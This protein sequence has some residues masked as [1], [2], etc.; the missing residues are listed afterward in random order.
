MS[1][2]LVNDCVVIPH[3][4][5][6]ANKVTHTR[7][8]STKVAEG[9]TGAEDRAQLKTQPIRALDCE[10]LAMDL[11]PRVELEER[12]LVAMQKGRAA[13]PLWS[14]PSEL[15]AQAGKTSVSLVNRVWPWRPGDY[16]IFMSPRGRGRNRTLQINCGGAA[17][18]PFLSDMDYT[19]GQPLS[20]ASAIRLGYAPDPAPAA[21]Y[22]TARVA[23][24]GTQEN[25]IAYAITGLDPAVGCMVRVHVAEIDP[26]MVPGS[27]NASPY[28]CPSA[29]QMSVTV[30]GDTVQTAANVVPFAA[31]HF[32]IYTPTVLEFW[33]YPDLTGTITITAAGIIESIY[34]GPTYYFP[35]LISALEVFQCSWEVRQLI[36][37]T[38]RG[39]LVWQD[40]LHGL[41]AASA[42]VYPLLM[43]TP[44]LRDSSALTDSLARLP[45]TVS[46][47]LGEG[48]PAVPGQCPTEVCYD[49]TV[50]YPGGGDPW[51]S[52]GNLTPS[53]VS[54]L[55]SIQGSYPLDTAW[56]NSPDAIAQA[57]G[58]SG[59]AGENLRAVFAAA[60]A[61]HSIPSDAVM[62]PMFWAVETSTGWMT[63]LGYAK[64][65]GI[66]GLTADPAPATSHQIDFTG[67]FGFILCAVYATGA[68]IGQIGPNLTPKTCAPYA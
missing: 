15:A 67:G 39:Q 36:T 55:P 57:N 16:A 23:T 58:V 6:W 41:Y 29:R 38:G 24:S 42:L 3:R 33:C 21:V 61:N 32:Q 40:T 2:E 5:D 43:G 31:A 46:E 64:S 60:V 10:I 25:V 56:T 20:T 68:T 18:P 26:V 28:G 44:S 62:G 1:V 49:C 37:P 4:V 9:I 22:Q 12:L 27:I 19:G 66:C 53:Q 48:A 13:V 51:P 45:I 63:E 8:W 14:R 11:Q 47:P 30:A 54:A 35:A 65:A 17:V 7:V 52:W 59:C 50:P 34:R